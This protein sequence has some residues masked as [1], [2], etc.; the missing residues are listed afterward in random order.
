M[1]M[2][3]H[4]PKYAVHKF[5]ESKFPETDWSNVIGNLP[6]IIW[7][8]RWNELAKTHGLPYRKGHI[9]NLDSR[10]IGP[11]SFIRNVPN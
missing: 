11:K 6:D 1:A 7:R 3:V 10:G 8:H 4:Y 9:E 5:L 2:T